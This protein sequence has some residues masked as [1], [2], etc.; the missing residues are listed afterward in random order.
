LNEGGY[1]VTINHPSKQI[2]YKIDD[3]DII[4]FG[5]AVYM[6]TISEPLTNYMRTLSY[7]NTNV[8]LYL[9]G[10]ATDVDTEIKMLEEI[11]CDAKKVKSIK[12]KKGE[13]A[14]IENFVEEFL[15]TI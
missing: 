5:S 10:L 6:G 3:Y 9:V 11:I 7:K 1:A 15:K 14:K 13:E 8:I 2:N 4:A 12:V